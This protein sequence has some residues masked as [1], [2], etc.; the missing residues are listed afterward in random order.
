MVGGSTSGRLGGALAAG[1]SAEAVTGEPSSGGGSGAAG[2][3]DFW[4]LSTWRCTACPA[5]SAAFFKS[6]R[7]PISVPLVDARVSHSI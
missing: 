3:D 7:K 4:R 1:G 2:G 6:S 5:L